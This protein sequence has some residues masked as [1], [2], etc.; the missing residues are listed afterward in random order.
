M[1]EP[2][3]TGAIVA[4]ELLCRTEIVFQEVDSGDCE[5][6]CWTTGYGVQVR[7][8]GNVIY[9]QDAWASCFD[10]SVVD[11]DELLDFLRTD[12]KLKSFRGIAFV[13]IDPEDIPEDFQL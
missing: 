1:C 8:D 7:K 13:G 3:S 12:L 4:P 6:G 9:E 11:W 10:N 5:Y 2:I